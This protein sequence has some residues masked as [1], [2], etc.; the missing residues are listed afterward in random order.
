MMRNTTL[1]LSFRTF[2]PNPL[3]R[4]TQNMHKCFFFLYLFTRSN[5][6]ENQHK[7]VFLRIFVEIYCLTL[8]LCNRNGESNRQR[9]QEQGKKKRRRKPMCSKLKLSER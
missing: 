5:L 6:P 3:Q 2:F 9:K 8:S 1:S 4:K 7:N